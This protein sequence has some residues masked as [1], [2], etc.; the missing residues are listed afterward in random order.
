MDFPAPRIH[1]FQIY[2]SAATRESLDPGFVPLDN[3]KNERPDWREYWPIR[4]FL[5]SNPPISGEYYGFLS[6]AFG[7]KTRLSSSAVIDFVRAQ[8]GKAD[9]VLFSPFFDQI[10][11][12]LN[13]WEQGVMAH[14]TSSF[15]FE[16]SLALI[17][18]EFRMLDTVGCSRDS[19][20]CNYF[21]AK[22]EFW[23]EWLERCERIFDCAERASTPLGH[24]LS[25]GIEYKSQAA[26]TKAFIIERVA[27]TLLATQRRWIA[28][29][30]NPMLL[31][32]SNS[33]VSALGAELAALD[34][35]K[36]AYLSE[37][38]Q[39]YKQAFFRLRA[40]FAKMQR[41]P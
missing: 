11:F 22:G 6:P 5:L 38:F 12:F 35:L 33:P 19:V 34:A 7:V 37:P 1:I 10:A 40:E 17:A 41:E 2:Y 16:Q 14:R 8:D 28:K 31:P 36:I 24:A 3:V 13:Q 30:Y 20:Y 32:Y 26:P 18:P 21:V 23:T 29:P 9:V 27:S 4:N 39:Q 25:A 15:A